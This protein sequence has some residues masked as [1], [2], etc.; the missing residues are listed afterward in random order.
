MVADAEERRA[1][2]RAE[3]LPLTPELRRFAHRIAPAE[4][5]ADDLVQDAF[6]RL[7]NSDWRAAASPV[8][9]LK[10]IIRNQ[11]YDLLRR[12]GLV[13]FRSLTD[14]DLSRLS[15]TTPDAERRL[16][17]MDELRRLSEVVAALPE[18]CRRTLIL[19]Q[20]HQLSMREIADRLSL[21]VSTVEKHLA[22]A[23]RLCSEGIAQQELQRGA[24]PR[25]DG[26]ER[27]RLASRPGRGG[28]VGRPDVRPARA[29]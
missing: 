2:F 14:L 24:E 16:I 15:E 28:P 9:V 7:L 13:P 20:V 29:D 17:G 18:Q 5:D 27:N 19:R 4:V 1:W 11:V 21:S 8:A 22:K 26:A 25:H 10:T 23:L 3:I 6:L 12:R